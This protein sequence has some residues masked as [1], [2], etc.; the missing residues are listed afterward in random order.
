M[1]FAK[2]DY[3]KHLGSN[4]SEN[5]KEMF[6]REIKDWKSGEGRGGAD[7]LPKKLLKE[8]AEMIKRLYK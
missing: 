6:Q 4:M 3:V 8:I 2:D 7:N 1:V 5:Q